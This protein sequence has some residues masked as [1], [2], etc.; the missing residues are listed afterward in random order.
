MTR[1]LYKHYC[2]STY[3]KI[4]VNTFFTELKVTIWTTKDINCF[5]NIR[6]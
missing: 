6:L 5:K 4:I 1:V 3:Q 2:D